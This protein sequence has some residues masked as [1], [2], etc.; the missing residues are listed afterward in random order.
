MGETAKQLFGAG[1]PLL[2]GY[3]FTRVSYYRR[4]KAEFMRTDH[5]AFYLLG[6]ALAFYLAGA[7]AAGLMPD[8]TFPGFAGVREGLEHIGF[9]APVANS[10]VVSIVWAWWCNARILWRVGPPPVPPDASSPRGKFRM[11]ALELFVRESSDANLRLL[12]RAAMLRKLIMVT[13]KSS[14]VYVGQPLIPDFE[15]SVRLASIRLLPLASGYRN[16][17]KRV[18]FTTHYDDIDERLAD[19][20]VVNDEPLRDRQDP[21]RVD[22]A[23]LSVAGQ[24]VPVDVEDFGIVVPWSEVESATIFD[25]NIYNAFQSNPA[26][27]N[28][29][30]PAP[31]GADLNGDA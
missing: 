11:A 28:P 20:D 22:M 26:E 1:F 12:F 16:E 18:I 24:S 15:P 31:P 7:V 2:S 14:K 29:V 3:I 27:T 6:Y 23:S 21:L 9:N 19:P 5:F 4:F 17:A 25:A 8:W 30:P 13:L 10:I